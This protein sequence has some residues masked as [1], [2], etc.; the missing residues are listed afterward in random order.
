MYDRRA[1]GDPLY[2]EESPLVF[3]IP[4]N[5][6]QAGGQPTLEISFAAMNGVSAVKIYVYDT[7]APNNN[8]V[9]TE[10]TVLRGA[11]GRSLRP[12]QL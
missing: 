8:V 5:R 1:W 6:I 3:A 9:L 7:D 4:G 10:V 11:P 2:C 12:T